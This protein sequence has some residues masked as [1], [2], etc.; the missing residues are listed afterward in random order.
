MKNKNERFDSR[1][2]N[3]PYRLNSERID[4]HKD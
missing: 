1:L 4:W 2:N 3:K